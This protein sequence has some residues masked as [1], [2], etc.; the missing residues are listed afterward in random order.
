MSRS[1]LPALFA[2]TALLYLTLACSLAAPVQTE[3]AP[4]ASQPQ[5]EQSGPPQS[6]AGVP[7][8]PAAE[9]KA[10][11][12]SGRAVIVDVRSQ[13]AYEA[14]HVAGALFIPLGA[15]ETDPAGVELDKEQWIITYCT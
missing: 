12:D 4:A 14:G 2:T 7:R 15:F 11:F 5:T 10:A 9:A 13:G 6:E 8:V 1:N 3:P